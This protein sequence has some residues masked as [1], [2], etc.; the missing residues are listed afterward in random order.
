LAFCVFAPLNISMAAPLCYRRFDPTSVPSPVSLKTKLSRQ[1]FPRKTIALFAIA[2]GIFFEPGVAFSAGGPTF[3]QE[4]DNQIQSGINVSVTLP[5]STTAGNLIVVFVVWDNSGD[6]SLTDNAG[7]AYVSAIGPTRWHAGRYSAQTFYAK[8]IKGGVDTV[9]G[10][11]TSAVSSFGTAYVHEYS[12]LDPIIPLDVAVATAGSSGP[13]NS[14][15]VA[16]LNATELLF[17]AGV[18]DGSVTSPGAGYT[19]RGNSHGDLTIDKVVSTQ[20][21]YDATAVNSGGAWAMQLATFRAT[22]TSIDTRA[23]TTPSNLIPT[24]VSAS[25]ITL[26]WAASM[27]NV[28]VAGYR[29]YRNGISIATSGTTSFSDGGLAPS[30]TY[31]YSVAALDAA[32][33]ISAP[34][35][36]ATETTFASLLGTYATT[37]PLTEHPIFENGN[38]SNGKA[39][40]L[41]WADVQTVG[42]LAYGS[43]SGSGG[44]DDSTAILTG[45]WGPDQT[46][47]ATVH[48][49]N[50]NSNVW[51]EVEIRLRSKITAYSCTGYEINFRCTHDGSQYVEIVRWNGP[52]GN[53]T[54]VAHLSGGPG[55][56]DGDVVKATINRNV[57]T[58]YINGTQVLQGTDSTYKNDTPG[59]GFYLSGAG[60]RNT[61]FGFTR[62]TATDGSPADTQV[63]TV[64][65]GLAATPVSP[66]R[67]DLTWTASSDNVGV[68]GYQLYRNGLGAGITAATTF[69]D[70]GLIANTAYTYAVAAFDVAGNLSAASATARVN[71]PSTDLNPPASPTNLQ[72]L[73]VGSNAVTITWSPSTD[74]VAVAGYRVFR[75]GS[76]V[77]TTILTSYTDTGLAALTTYGYTVVAFDTSNNISTQSQQ[78]FVTTTAATSSLPPRFVQVSHNQIIRGTSTS[79]TLSAPIQTGNTIVAYVIW[80]NTGKVTCS[81]TRGNTFVAAASPVTWGANYRAQIF[82]ATNIKGGTD[83]VTVK[84]QNAVGAFGVLYIHEYAGIDPVTPVDATASASGTSTAMTSGAALTTQPNDLIFG[85]G[86]SDGTVNAAGSGFIARDFGYGNITEDRIAT[87]AGTF[88]ATATQSGNAW[89]MQVVAF[90]PAK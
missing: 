34:S 45:T 27:D 79:I 63:P 29:I 74:N 89:G 39:D 68:A 46:A 9:A 83:K 22:T 47:E 28:G 67:V 60:I 24:A 10:T 58:A 69:S 62:F 19:I 88:A 36:G 87:F 44:Y 55:I 72:T 41:D 21:A 8:N 31:T 43:E 64:P 49:V 54:Y 37:F 57:I 61:D 65:A 80:S 51:E 76:Q 53:F 11:F 32:G 7:N 73:R 90:R 40:G 82:Y 85:A 15:S 42:G 84:F 25:Q 38:W 71:T 18:S 86:V 81:D 50:Q 5:W 30:T 12:G 1:L 66:S 52:L 77:G 35:A 56:Q 6:V 70:T 26:G 14:G 17:G 20:G 33:N 75:N 78:L 13:L 48:S 4:N 59:I 16:T 2:F 3:V 23:P